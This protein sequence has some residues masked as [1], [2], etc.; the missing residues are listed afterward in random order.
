PSK[1]PRSGRTTSA[2]DGSSFA[3]A[4]LARGCRIPPTTKERPMWS[5]EEVRRAAV[6]WRAAHAALTEAARDG[7]DNTFQRALADAAVPIAWL[8]KLFGVNKRTIERW[9][10]ADNIT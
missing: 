3:A 6:N 7:D 9:I 10:T 2:A 8:P 1:P 5:E 4:R